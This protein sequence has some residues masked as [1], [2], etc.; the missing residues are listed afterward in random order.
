MRVSYKT[1]YGDVQL[2]LLKC[3]ATL[4]G[5]C[6]L[7]KEGWRQADILHSNWR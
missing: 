1:D 4:G 6:I 7:E 2:L 3:I 5:L